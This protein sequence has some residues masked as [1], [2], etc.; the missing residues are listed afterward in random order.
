MGKCQHA[1]CKYKANHII[2]GHQFCARHVKMFLR[3]VLDGK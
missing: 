3:A 1:G 2:G